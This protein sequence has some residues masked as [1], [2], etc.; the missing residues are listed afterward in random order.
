MKEEIVVY[1]E[2]T[3]DSCG[4]SAENILQIPSPIPKP[5]FV[6]VALLFPKKVHS[7]CIG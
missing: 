2:M 3:N 6:A 4:I 5:T 7:S 1:I